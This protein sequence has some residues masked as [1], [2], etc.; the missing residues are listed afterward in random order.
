MA[1]YISYEDM[2]TMPKHEVIAGLE[3]HSLHYNPDWDLGRLRR[4]LG[5]ALVYRQATTYK[6]KDQYSKRTP[7]DYNFYDEDK[8]LLDTEICYRTGSDRVYVFLV[9]MFE[10]AR[11]AVPLFT[12]WEQLAS[13]GE[14]K[15]SSGSCP[16]Y[17][18]RFPTIRPE[19][20]SFYAIT[21]T[22]DMAF[23]LFY[24]SYNNWA[25]A[26]TWADR[27][28]VGLMKRVLL[29]LD[30]YG[31][32]LGAGACTGNCRPCTLA[33]GEGCKKPKYRRHSMEATGINCDLLHRRFYGE[34]LPWAYKGLNLIPTYMSRYGGFLANLQGNT[35][36]RFLMNA[37]RKDDHYI[38]RQPPIEPEYEPIVREIPS[39]IHKG[40]TQYFYS[41]TDAERI[42]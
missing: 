41:L 32:V 9:Q 25:R 5:M 33:R 1:M 16:G 31:Y 26:I 20:G 22:L 11:D 14:C 24:N 21:I 15:G 39:G 23:C 12:E 8:V 38:D 35:A 29:R 30:Q 19:L 2:R 34:Y 36:A 4:T 28:S 37:L 42:R 27:L 40:S 18:P 13:C 7:F 17:A 6:P 10:V 3:A